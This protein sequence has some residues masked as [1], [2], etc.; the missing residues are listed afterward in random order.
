MEHRPLRKCIVNKICGVFVHFDS[1]GVFAAET[2][3]P[4]CVHIV[5]RA[6]FCLPFFSRM[7]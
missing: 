2:A 6:W 7:T 1:G 5:H 3:G 4:V